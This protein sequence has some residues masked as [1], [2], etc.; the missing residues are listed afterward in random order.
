MTGLYVVKRN[1]KEEVER[2]RRNRFERLH[3][4]ALAIEA[5]DAKSSGNLGFV[6]KWIVHAALP[7]RDPGDKP[8]WGR[9]SGDLSLVIQPGFFKRA[10][11]VKDH[12]G[13]ERTTDELVSV[14]FPYGSY[15]R[16]LL[17]W[18]A[19]EVVRTRQ[20]EI[21]L[22]VSVADFMQ[23][24]GKNSV[25]GGPRGTITLL[26]NQMMRLFSAT[27]AVT[28]D[29][30]AVVW[31]NDGFRLLDQS[32]IE[33][34]WSPSDPRQLSLFKSTIKLSERFYTTLIEHPIPV[35]LRVLKT[36]ARSPLSIDIYCWLTYRSAILSRP[37][38]V[39][40]ESLSQQ[41]GSES[42]FA[43]FKE[44]FLKN[45]RDVLLVY[46]KARVRPERAGLH[47]APAPPSVAKRIQRA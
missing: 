24:L 15:P 18:M 2:A 14:G 1:S 47:V 17:A 23:Q 6:A 34:F 12:R 21:A 44:N 41:F 39:P 37:T 25:S 5:D 3:A 8:A 33:T 45:L 11:R 29:P 13:K 46:P 30:D 31:Q 36:L 28:S 38:L 43:K 35:D 7:Y 10:V 40:W 27:I 19:T 22:G 26:K 9:R 42:S 16:L 4:E 20:R 32:M